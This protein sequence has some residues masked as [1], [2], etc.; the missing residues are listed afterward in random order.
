MR[1][2]NTFGTLE[3]AICSFEVTISSMKVRLKIMTNFNAS[4]TAVLY[5]SE[6]MAR[7]CYICP[8]T[9]SSPSYM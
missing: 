3:I 6:K 2:T 7:V 5:A 8:Y 1:N 4:G 9:D